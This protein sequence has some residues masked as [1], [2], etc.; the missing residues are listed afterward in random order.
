MTQPLMA[1]TTRTVSPVMTIP[2]SQS[3]IER[4][5][6]SVFPRNGGKEL[7]Q[8]FP[9]KPVH[10]NSFHRNRRAFLREP[11]RRTECR[12]LHMATSR[13]KTLSITAATV[14]LATGICVS[15]VLTPRHSGLV[16]LCLSSHARFIDQ[17]TSGAG[18]RFRELAVKGNDKRPALC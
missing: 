17:S 2:G 16:L 6:N 8:P 14:G 13:L 5:S 3:N 11:L 12:A 7:R 9:S 1:T 18:G 15:D 10:K 4:G